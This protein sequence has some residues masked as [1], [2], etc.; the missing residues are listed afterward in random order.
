MIINLSFT[1]S[2]LYQIIKIKL[3]FKNIAHLSHD[4]YIDLSEKANW[5]KYNQIKIY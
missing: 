3:N 1:D 4:K 5:G 2:I